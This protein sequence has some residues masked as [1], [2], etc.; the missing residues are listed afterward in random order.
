VKFERVFGVVYTGKALAD[1]KAWW[2][3]IFAKRPIPWWEKHRAIPVLQSLAA[4]PVACER[5]GLELEIQ[6]DAGES[7]GSYVADTI[8]QLCLD[9]EIEISEQRHAELLKK[10]AHPTHNGDDNGK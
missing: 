6:L 3:R 10:Q 7:V 9:M 8:A 1:L 4:N 2:E 5:L